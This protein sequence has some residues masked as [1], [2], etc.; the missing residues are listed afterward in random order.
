MPTFAKEFD[1]KFQNAR[2]RVLPQRDHAKPNGKMSRHYGTDNNEF[3]TPGAIVG[4]SLDDFYAY[5]PMHAY[6]FSP[7]GELWPAS[8][9]D[10]RFPLQPLVYPDGSPLR[11][12]DGR[13]KT[14]KA[15]RWLDRNK[16][17]EQ[18]TWAPGEPKIIKERLISEGGWIERPGCR[19]FNLYKP[20]MIIRGN[21]RKADPWI[22]HLSRVYGENTLHI[23]RWLAHRVQRP[24]EKINHALVFGGAQGIGKDTLLEPVK[25]AIGPWNFVEVSPKHM[26]GRFNSFARSVI[27]RISEARDL[28]K[29]TV[30]R[31]MTT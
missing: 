9:V 1:D 4:V 2:Q 28:G 31:S 19:C 27:L 8:S 6:I 16:A 18:M 13:R 3:V 23:T 30:S 12:Q 25:V 5:M 29:S 7:S 11:K 21:P 10:L 14:I 26:L 20:P 24:R 17:V 22:E 15:S